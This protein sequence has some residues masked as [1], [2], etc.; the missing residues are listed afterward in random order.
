MT[1][2]AERRTRRKPKVRWYIVGALAAIVSL[3]ALLYICA[4]LLAREVLSFEL[5]EELVI[6]C[7]FFSSTIAAVAACAGR[8]GKAMQ[9]GL[10]MGGG[11][12][13]AI[14]IICLAAP[15]EGPFNACTLR[16]V[17]A[18]VTGGAFG[19]AWCIKRGTRS[20]RRKKRK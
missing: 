7:V 6:A 20:A 12:A 17:I 4:I 3:P 9:T 10:V 18:A 13:A 8:G 15:G 16:H 5:M 14:V 11:I 2:Q 19:G 1:A